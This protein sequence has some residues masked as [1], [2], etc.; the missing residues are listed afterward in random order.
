MANFG[1]QKRAVALCSASL[2]SDYP[3][4]WYACWSI[5]FKRPCIIV[6]LSNFVHYPCKVLSMFP[7]S[8][9]HYIQIK[10]LGEEHP[11]YCH[12]EQPA[13]KQTSQKGQHMHCAWPYPKPK[14]IVR[15]A[16]KFLLGKKK[17]STS[18]LEANWFDA[19]HS[20]PEKLHPQPTA[21]THT[22]TSTSHLMT[23]NDLQQPSGPNNRCT[24]PSEVTE[25]RQPCLL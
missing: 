3:C 5:F 11:C 13:W 4:L 1:W 7:S 16:P 12:T 18:K 23:H 10:L 14:W 22:A 2:C 15:G 21:E 24:L 9:A 19:P 17:K 20:I 25:L 8:D 6:M